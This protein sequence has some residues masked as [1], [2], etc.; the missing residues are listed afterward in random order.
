MTWPPGPGGKLTWR[1]GPPRGCDAALRPRGWAA[2]GTHEVHR[3]RTCGRRP[4]VFTHP[5][6]G[7]SGVPRGRGGSVTCPFRASLN[8]KTM[9]KQ[10]L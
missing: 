9:V 7:P 2:G 8:T 1:A 4:R 6:R 5:R 3:A 10:N